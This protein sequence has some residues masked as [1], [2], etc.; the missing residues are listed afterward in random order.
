MEILEKRYKAVSKAVSKEYLIKKDSIDWGGM[1]SWRRAVQ[2]SIDGIE[3]NY[4]VG[5]IVEA[6][7]RKEAERMRAF[8][9]PYKQHLEKVMNSELMSVIGE[10]TRLDG[11]KKGL[12]NDLKYRRITQAEFDTRIAPINSGIADLE[13]TV[14]ANRGRYLREATSLG[15]GPF[16]G[17]GYL[18]KDSYTQVYERRLLEEVVAVDFARP[19]SKGK[20]KR[21]GDVVAEV[22]GN[23]AGRAI[24]IISRLEYEYQVM[25]IEE[26]FDAVESGKFLERYI[27]NKA[28]GYIN[29]ATPSYWVKKGLDKVHSLGLKTGDDDDFEKTMLGKLSGLGTIAGMHKSVSKERLETI[30]SIHELKISRSNPTNTAADIAAIDQS[31]ADART[32]FAALQRT[33]EATNMAA[34]GNLWGNWFKVKFEG[35]RA[36]RRGEVDAFTAGVRISARLYGGGHFAGIKGLSE[37]RAMVRSGEWT[38]EALA[39]FIKNV[40]PDGLSD[41]SFLRRL[42]LLNKRRAI[43][44]P[45]GMDQAEFA[46]QVMEL[47][48]WVLKHRHR[49]STNVDMDSDAFWLS[50]VD[51]MANKMRDPDFNLIGITK[52]YAGLFEKVWNKL[53]EFQTMVFVKFG[54][55]LAPVSYVKT[56]IAE[57]IADLIPKL[58]ALLGGAASGG[59]LAIL[60]EKIGRILR[61]IIRFLVKKSLD[62]VQNFVGGLIH[63]D[64]GKALAELDKQV[65]ALIKA[66]LIFSSVPII[67]TVALST[68]FFG[69]STTTI[70]PIDPT[71]S[72]G[73]V[74]YFGAG[75]GNFTGN[76]TDMIGPG[77]PAANEGCFVF[78]NNDEI[79]TCNGTNYQLLDWP[80]PPLSTFQAAARAIMGT[81][82]GNRLCASN[83]SIRVFWAESPVGQFG[84]TSS[85]CWWGETC[86]ANSF[87]LNNAIP[88]TISNHYSTYLFAHESGHV[89]YHRYGEAFETVPGAITFSTALSEGKNPTYP[90]GCGTQSNNEDYAETI[91]NYFWVNVADC[92][93]IPGSSYTEYWSQF[94]RHWQYIQEVL[95]RP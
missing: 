14:R 5:G 44:L 54:K 71:R 87:V 78:E 22:P 74:D 51:M 25:Q 45:P 75:L 18:Y 6:V 24:G 95:F 59:T 55:I 60:L 16:N 34:P 40:G 1:A 15:M 77:S 72:A 49:I 57:K 31:I 68:M 83:T 84:C 43:I 69:A 63:G 33:S 38:P 50:F 62:F 32:R 35:G 85:G 90:G 67:I 10:N 88:T 42:L 86:G 46:S 30:K 19:R 64:F 37:I 82:Y 76:P 89:W 48:E 80:N 39:F 41:P 79:L 58:L 61:P 36:N 13:Q 7:D 3:N 91:G 53:N 66:L 73:E 12:E 8:L 28:K 27:W 21:I 92:P 81:G 65:Q 4:G 93:N 17:R 11:L 9:D 94:P 52:R 2:E 20:N 70:S 23:Y 47:R 29:S 26:F 56:F